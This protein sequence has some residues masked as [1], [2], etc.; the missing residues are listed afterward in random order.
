MISDVQS[1]LK[2]LNNSQ[3][4]LY[5]HADITVYVDAQVVVARMVKLV[6]DGLNNANQAI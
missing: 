5:A 4:D 2:Q 1:T 3:C 6:T